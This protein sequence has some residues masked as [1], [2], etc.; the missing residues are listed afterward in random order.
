MHQKLNIFVNLSIKIQHI[1]TICANTKVFLFFFQ[2][3]TLKF[4]Y[5]K[6]FSVCVVLDYY[7]KGLILH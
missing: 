1:L 6:K 7:L 4:T 2:Q 3:K 5:L